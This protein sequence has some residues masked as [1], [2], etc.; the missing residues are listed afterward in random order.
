MA[1]CIKCGKQNADNAKFCTACGNVLVK[2]SPVMQEKPVQQHQAQPSYSNATT[3]GGTPPAPIK[4]SNAAIKWVIIVVIAAGFLTGGYFMFGDKLFG[5][6]KTSAESNRDALPNN[7]NTVVPADTVLVQ[8]P[9]QQN[10]QSSQVLTPGNRT[11]SQGGGAI[12]QKETDD[13][14]ALM[15][16][17]FEADNAENIPAILGYFSYPVKRYYN[18]NDVSYEKLETLFQSAF[19]TTLLHHSINVNW[20]GSVVEKTAY[21]YL[22]KVNATYDFA[23]QKKPEEEK[24]RIINVVILMNGNRQITTIYENP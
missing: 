11:L 1:F 24:S 7:L 10:Q 2:S 13:I 14:S 15:K 9:S 4:N 3:A 5:E 6:K 20:E 21:G 19:S 12:T 17:F 23:T 8:Q 16:T 22:V 18:M